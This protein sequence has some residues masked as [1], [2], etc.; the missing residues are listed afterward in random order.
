[1]SLNRLPQIAALVIAAGAFAPAFVAPA[2][3]AKPEV[4]KLS[5][6]VVRDLHFGDALFYYY[7]GKDQQAIDYWDQVL[8][9]DKEHASA[10][11]MIG[12][13]YQKKGEKE[14][15]QQLCDRA[16]QMDPKL[17]SL[18]EEKKMPGGI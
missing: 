11:Y 10:L 18:K 9:Y 15:G 3:A 2:M 1:M 8:F 4:D 6:T 12:M 16:I 5:P 17:K 14:K 7:Q 13:S